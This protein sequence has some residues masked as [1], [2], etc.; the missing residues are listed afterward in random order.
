MSGDSPVALVT[1]SHGGI[2]R[3]TVKALAD[4]GFQ[5]AGVSRQ[6]DDDLEGLALGIPADLTDAEACQAVMDQVAR[7]FGRLD[8]LVNNAGVN[9]WQRFEDWDSG[10][11]RQVFEVNVWGSLN[12]T[13]AATGLLSKGT[14]SSVVFTTSSAGSRGIS[15]TAAYG[16]TKAALES[17]TRT[18][19]IEWARIP[20][21]VNAV[22]ATI[23]P[24]DMNREA[25][26]SPDYL[27]AKIATIPMA[28]MIEPAEVA[29]AI[30]FLASEASS[31][32][33]GTTLHVDGGVTARG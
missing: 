15:G 30:A 11:A 14:R 6:A 2:G 8:A 31:G 12:I 19:A 25:R 32:I 33:T 26:S 17:C 24:T 1:G 16:M 27:T 20:I 10:A 4:V 18:L 13:H 23:V 28:R 3:E 9:L 21:R 5:V 22:S 29:R 7:K